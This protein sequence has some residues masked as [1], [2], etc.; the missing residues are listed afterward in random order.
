MGGGT[1]RCVNARRV[2][3]GLSPRGRGNPSI[4]WRVPNST[5]SIPAWA[6]EPRVT[7]PL[8]SALPV[9][10]RVGGGTPADPD[11]GMRPLGLSPRGRGNLFPLT[12]PI[13][14]TRSIPAWAGE[15]PVG[16]FWGCSRWVYPRVGGGTPDFY[17]QIVAEEGLSPRGRGNQVIRKPISTLLRSIPA[18]AG[19]PAGT[20][21]PAIS[22]TVYP[23]VGGGTYG[24]CPGDTRGAGLSPRGRGNPIRVCCPSPEIGS[25]P[26]WAGEPLGVGQR[27]HPVG[28][29]PRVGGGTGKMRETNPVTAGLSPRG[30]GNRDK[31]KVDS[32]DVRSIPAWA[33]EPL[34]R[35]ERR[36]A[37]GVYPRVGGGT[38]IVGVIA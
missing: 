8:G 7:T 23:R 25:I 32:A 37:T 12:S 30:R 1:L 10:P 36:W 14:I 35:P 20:A 28:V 38:F 33:G 27:V 13:Y 18:W 19:E 2:A 26:A 17:Q 34:R 3:T 22:T 15:P 9:Y 21:I 29:Y 11:L 6:G 31:D 24:S 16:G 5:R 4:F